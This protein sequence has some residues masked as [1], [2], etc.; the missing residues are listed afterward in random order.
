M[1]T[2]DHQAL[3]GEVGKQRN[4]LSLE[5]KFGQE[6][7][8]LVALFC[9]KKDLFKSDFCFT[10]NQLLG[11]VSVESAPVVEERLNYLTEG[12]CTE[13]KLG[14]LG[15]LVRSGEEVEQHWRS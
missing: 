13:L 8:F 4:V 6:V 15:S 9:I 5:L 12:S 14:S 7:H 3:I 11:R 10:F 1:N 2:L